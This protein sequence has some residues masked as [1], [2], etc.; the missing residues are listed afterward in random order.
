MLLK[1]IPAWAPPPRP[2][3]LDSLLGPSMNISGMLP[4]DSN[5][6]DQWHSD[7]NLGSGIKLLG[8]TL[9][10]CRIMAFGLRQYT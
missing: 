2:I 10:I 4:G 3:K 6:T 8:V 7:Q 1:G 5:V 9:K